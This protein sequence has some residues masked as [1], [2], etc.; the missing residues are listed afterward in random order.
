MQRYLCIHGHFYQPPRENPWLEAVELQDSAYPYHDWNER[1]T[2]ECYAPN[3]AS[4]ILDQQNRIERIVN[5]Y[6]QISFNFGPTLLAWMETKAKRAY[7]RIV[8]ADAASRY[9]FSGH[10]SALAQPYNHIILPLAN[11]RD[12]RTQILWGLADFE[13]RFG[14]PAE[15][16]WLPE[17]AVDLETL[18]LLAAEGVRFTIL[19]PHQARRV[20]IMDSRRP[21]DWRDVSGGRVDTTIPYEAVLPS[22]RRIALFFYDG[23][24]SRAVAFEGLLSSGERF[25]DRLM[26]VVPPSPDRDRLINI[27]T[28]GETYGHHH[29]YGEMALSYALDRIEANGWARLTNYGEYL[30]THPPEHQVEIVENTSWSCAHGV[31]RWREDCGCHTGG[32][33]GWNQAWRAPF[34]QALDWLRDE[35]APRYEEAAEAFFPDPWAARD[36]YIQVV[37]DRS[38]ESV[39]AFLERHAGGHSPTGEDRV[40]ALKLL[41]LQRQAM[42][43]YTSCGWFFNDLAGIE[44]VQVLRYAGRAVQLAGQLF[45][46]PLEPELLRR[47]DRARSNDPAAGSGRDIYE[48]LVR[49]SVVDLPQVAAHYAV[50]SLFEDFPDSAPVYCYSVERENGRAFRAGRS[51]LAVGRVRVTSTVTGKAG[52]FV[53]GVLHFGD[54]NLN[55]G[56][57][58]FEEGEAYHRLIVEAGGAFEHGDLARVVRL[59]DRYFGDVSYSLKSLFRDEQRR[60]LDLILASTLEEVEDELRDIFRHHAP[61]MRFL[62]SLGTPL[63]KAFRAAAELVLNV[64]LK[65]ALSDFS[66][67]F[68]EVGR[69]LDETASL[70]IDLDTEGLSYALG[71]ALKDLVELFRERPDD[72]DLLRRMD[73]IVTLTRSTPFKVDL[74]RAQNRCYE[75]RQT[76]DPRLKERAGAGDAR[77][78]EWVE[79][80]RELGEKLAV[81]VE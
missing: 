75:L 59:L 55:A 46:E 60:I 8:E 47:L 51:K 73:A 27:A 2:A 53:F 54:H 58:R 38:P 10:G 37:L 43:M 39:A 57:E 22:G 20:R 35:L 24:V 77:A 48:R 9:R 78:A 49:P 29:R 33:A 26:S 66:T 19:E 74:W 28:D 72:P 3:T 69:L 31:D 17:T 1:I 13:R 70:H 41:E 44:T 63:P 56:V 30:E 68:E 4:R 64:D 18:D 50:A 67:D 36:G 45:G 12:K 15:G 40:R 5:N 80:F 21:E 81:R 34:R 62:N 11:R 79:L 6:A 32:N 52:C 14:R 23:A 65:R 42:L 61:L 16:V 7:Q 25:A 71:L 76:I